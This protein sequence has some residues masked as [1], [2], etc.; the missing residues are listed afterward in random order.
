MFGS[1]ILVY[2][3]TAIWGRRCIWGMIGFLSVFLSLVSLSLSLFCVLCSWRRAACTLTAISSS[4]RMKGGEG[5]KIT[6]ISVVSYEM[7]TK[8][9]TYHNITVR[10]DR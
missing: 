4:V 10:N 8:S 1:K 2:C 7:S 3:G 6:E 5:C 9:G